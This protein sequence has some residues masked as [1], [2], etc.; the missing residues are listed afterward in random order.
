MC[1][2]HLLYSVLFG[3]ALG[4]VHTYLGCEI[5]MGLTLE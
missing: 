4:V 5:L 3:G 1:S 2:T